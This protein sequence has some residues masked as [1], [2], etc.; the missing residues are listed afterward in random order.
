MIEMEKDILFFT[1]KSLGI[2]M[3]E[4]GGVGKYITF[5]CDDAEVSI[6]VESFDAFTNAVVMANDMWYGRDSKKGD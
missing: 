4:E 2:E 6:E 1:A 3:S 5:I